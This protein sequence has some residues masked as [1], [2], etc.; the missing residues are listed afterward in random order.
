VGDL[1]FDFDVVFGSSGN[2]LS[3][4]ELWF[5]STGKNLDHIMFCCDQGK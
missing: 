1:V 5:V 2:N 4:V 3:V